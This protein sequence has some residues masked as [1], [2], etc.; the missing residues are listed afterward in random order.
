MSGTF[1]ISCAYTGSW[2]CWREGLDRFAYTRYPRRCP[3]HVGAWS[4]GPLWPQ[5]ASGRSSPGNAGGSSSLDSLPTPWDYP[6]ERV[7]VEISFML[8][9]TMCKENCYQSL[10]LRQNELRFAAFL[11]SF[12]RKLVLVWQFKYAWFKLSSNSWTKIPYTVADTS[13]ALWP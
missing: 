10:D 4:G 8:K 13:R 2:R 1:F 12:P 9:E 6:I 11:C 7:D 5:G 3:R